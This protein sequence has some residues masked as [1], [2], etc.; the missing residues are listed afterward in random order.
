MDAAKE[1]MEKRRSEKPKSFRSDPQ[2]VL[3]WKESNY[4]SIVKKFTA[5]WRSLSSATAKAPELED[6]G[7]T[8]EA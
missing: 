7:R 5:D 8:P 2:V 4:K 3:T 1:M 6:S